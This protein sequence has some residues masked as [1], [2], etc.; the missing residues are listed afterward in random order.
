MKNLNQSWHSLIFWIISLRFDF[1]SNLKALTSALLDIFFLQLYERFL[2]VSSWNFQIIDLKFPFWIK[3]FAVKAERSFN[4]RW[5]STRSGRATMSL[6][7]NFV[8]S[9]SPRCKNKRQFWLR[10]EKK[11][12]KSRRQKE[13]RNHYAV[14]FIPSSL[15]YSWSEKLTKW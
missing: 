8:P 2:R 11:K 12:L 5:L 15:M 14:I 3:F 9:F 7:G 1:C 6:Q 10:T 4:L 13:A